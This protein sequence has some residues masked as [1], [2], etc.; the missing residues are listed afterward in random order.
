MPNSNQ[1]P[2]DDPIF[3]FEEKKKVELER[4]TI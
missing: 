2:I 4:R 3:T 1:N